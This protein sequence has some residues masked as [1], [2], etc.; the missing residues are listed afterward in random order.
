[1]LENIHT[2]KYWQRMGKK[3]SEEL[4]DLRP[5]F[6]CEKKKK[7]LMTALDR[8]SHEWLYVYLTN[9]TS[10]SRKWQI[11]KWITDALKSKFSFS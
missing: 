6:V 3:F 1:M 11:L 5:I 4:Q 9:P 2:E 7:N 10:K 8:T